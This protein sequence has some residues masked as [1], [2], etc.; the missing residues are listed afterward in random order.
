MKPN[1]DKSGERI[2]T[3]E[4]IAIDIINHIKKTVSL[5][6]AEIKSKWLIDG[7]SENTA[8]NNSSIMADKFRDELLSEHGYV[9]GQFIT[10]DD[11][12]NLEQE[13]INLGVD[14]TI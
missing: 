10:L 3:T 5:Y 1:F 9:R 8:E 11:Y 4:K 6:K 7:A 12:N 14:L 13:M 2:V